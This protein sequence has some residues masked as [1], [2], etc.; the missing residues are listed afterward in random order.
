ME[1][2]VF[3]SSYMKKVSATAVMWDIFS[4]DRH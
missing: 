3:M 2:Y 1:E 4:M